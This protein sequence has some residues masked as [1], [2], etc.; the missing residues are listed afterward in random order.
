MKSFIVNVPT[1]RREC[2][3]ALATPFRRASLKQLFWTAGIAGTLAVTSWINYAANASDAAMRKQMRTEEEGIRG[4]IEEG[5]TKC[6]SY[7]YEKAGRTF[8]RVLTAN[9]AELRAQAISAVTVCGQRSDDA[10]KRIQVEPQ[11]PS[12]VPAFLWTIA[13]MGLGGYTAAA[14]SKRKKPAVPESNPG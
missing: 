9:H 3:T 12:P 4:I 2:M 13:A 8:V 1:T 5:R 7:E 6:I 14:Y 11:Q 10:L